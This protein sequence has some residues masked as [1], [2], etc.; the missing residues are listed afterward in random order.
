VIQLDVM[1][2][3]AWRD[4]L[5][6]PDGGRTCALPGE[7]NGS[8]GPPLGASRHQRPC[9]EGSLLRLFG[10]SR[11]GYSPKFV[12]HARF[13]DLLRRHRPAKIGEGPGS[14]E[15]SSRARGNPIKIVL[16]L[17]VVLLF[18][19]LAV[20]GLVL[21]QRL[22]PIERRLA[23]NDVAGFIYAVLGV[24]YA[25]LLGLM[26]VAVWQDWQA[27]QETATQDGDPGSQRAGRR[28]L[29]RPRPAR[30]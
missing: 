30:A 18:V 24:A 12:R 4:C 15:R 8:E 17:L 1:H 26:V 7:E 27:A 21:V 16:G 3:S 20:G 28:L 13:P 22:V 23:H 10:Q 2:R 29:A 11:K 25:V 6:N 9:L 14:Q 5:K 19:A